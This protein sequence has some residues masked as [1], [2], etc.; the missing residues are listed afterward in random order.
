MLKG[1]RL[2]FDARDGRRLFDAALG[3]VS[4]VTF[5]WYYFGGGVKL[6]I[7]T[8]RYRVSF[9]RPGNLPDVPIETVGDLPSARESGKMWKSVLADSIT[10]R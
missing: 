7:G 1:E 6:R 9:A 3:E 4:D 8:D 5:P 10:N 2:V